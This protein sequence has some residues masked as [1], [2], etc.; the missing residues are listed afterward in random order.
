MNHCNILL[1]GLIR[2]R[3][4][5][6]E[7]GGT[8]CGVYQVCEDKGKVDGGRFNKEQYQATGQ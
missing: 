7:L 2:P 3:L 1:P 6:G 8:Q 5:G 4:R